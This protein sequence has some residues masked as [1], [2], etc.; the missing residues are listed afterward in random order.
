MVS[1]GESVENDPPFSAC[2]HSQ[3]YEKKEAAQGPFSVLLNCIVK[4]EDEN[5]VQQ[6]SRLI[7]LLFCLAGL[8]L[9]ENSLILFS[10]L[11]GKN[12]QSHRGVGN[13]SKILRVVI[14]RIVSEPFILIF[15]SAGTIRIFKNRPQS[16]DFSTSLALLEI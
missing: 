3:G 5:C 13:L 1:G 16:S 6:R 9:A 11:L 8:Q 2:S 7:Q 4:K 15:T 10:T 14:Q 12:C